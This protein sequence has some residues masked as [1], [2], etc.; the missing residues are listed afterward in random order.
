MTLPPSR[1][2]RPAL[3][4]RP[5]FVAALVL[6][7]GLGFAAELRSYARPDTGF[8]LDAAARLLGGARLY[9]DIVE[10]NP[11]LIVLLN[12]PAVV[13]GGGLGLSDILVYRVGCAL[14]LLGL[15]ALAAVWLRRTLPDERARR[16]LVLLLAFAYFPLAGQDFGEREHLVV[17][18][19][20]PFLLLGASRALRR[21]V[22]RADAV[23]V[24]LLAGL[25]LALKPHFAVVWLLV[26]GYLVLKRRVPPARLVPETAA[27][28]G[29]LAAYGIVVVVFFPQYFGLVRLLAVPYGQFL[30]DSF[31]HLLV[32]G[33]GAALTLF[34]LLAVLALRQ[35]ARH[36]EVWWLL[37][38]GTVG[39][40]LAGAVQ[41]KGLR[42]HFYP[43]FALAT[44][45]LG[46]VVTD[47]ARPFPN[48]VRR[49][50]HT[51]AVSV[52]GTLALVVAAQ[53]AVQ[54]AGAAH[55]AERDGLE[56]LVTLVRE[57]AAGQPVF[58]MSYHIGSAYPLLNYSGA[59][60]ASRFGHL[61]ILAAAYADALR[62]DEPLRYREPAAM[63]PSERYLVA[64]VRADLTAA[65][66]R[67]LIVLRH[68]R[69][70]PTNGYRRLDYLAY[71]ARDPAIAA[72]LARYRLLANV[73]EY[74]VYERL[75]EGAAPVAEAPAP[76][77]GTQ[78]I[79]TGERAGIHL[80]LR[81]PQFL[82][83]VGIFLLVLAWAVARERR[84][85]D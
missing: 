37:A 4:R 67:L 59:R 10:I 44:V 40:F 31:F 30:Y 62:A 9:T 82:M 15:L 41:Q 8:L 75:P 7:V 27:V 23:V 24:G 73:G 29:F 50:Y 38:L 81:D 36:P 66:P 55:D 47:V 58:V 17:A 70:V 20:V 45:L 13:V 71:F 83:A 60:A 80:R 49:V 56:E 5:V 21:E 2:S 14:T 51:L 46:L 26:T 76:V 74:A 68:A 28:A 18:C 69:D 52:L 1:A 34:A 22:G 53:N 77:P 79:L 39:C 6:L 16:R 19:L 65:R 25:A 43:S 85:R 32:T 11:P 84:W 64:A 35:H 3:E 12:V 54:A 33:P 57:R 48:W 72:A 63:P 78:D 42:Y 61:W